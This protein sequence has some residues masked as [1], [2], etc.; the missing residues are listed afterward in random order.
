MLRSLRFWLLW[1]PC[2]YQL[3]TDPQ[4]VGIPFSLFTGLFI[5]ILAPEVYQPL[6]DMGTHYHAKAQ[7]V[8]A[9]EAL[10]TLLNI[11]NLEFVGQMRI[12]SIET[13][14]ADHLE[15]F[16]V[17]G[18]RLLGPLS[19]ELKDNQ[20]LGFSWPKAVRKTSLLNAYWDFTL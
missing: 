10:I 9:A 12:N 18:T 3:S 2:Q 6:R 17:D 1:R 11:L 20:R 8:G 4:I 19:F 7:A 13:L 15:V 14:S 16:S 5:L